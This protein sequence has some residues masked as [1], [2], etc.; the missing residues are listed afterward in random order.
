LGHEQHP[1]DIEEDGIAVDT[2][3]PSCDESGNTTFES[4]EELT[5]SDDDTAIAAK[6]PA[7]GGSAPATGGVTGGSAPATGGKKSGASIF[8]NGYFYIKGHEL[9]LRMY[10]FNKWMAP[11][12]NGIG[13]LPTSTKTITP[14]LIGESR[15]HPTRSL[16]LLKAWMLWRAR[17][18]PGWV[19]GSAS[20]Q[21]LFREEE[22]Q[23][24]LE[25]K[26]LQPQTDGLL[27]NPSASK[28]LREW[29]P[30]VVTLLSQPLAAS[31]AKGD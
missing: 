18:A 22:D 9:D 20:R 28:L 6:K 7:T 1:S 15:E 24:Y 21:R 16:L 4:S 10:I 31:S 27:G 30:Q 26:S 23:L 11:L 17:G 3:E 19:E 13:K 5:D 8:D 29:A 12:P 25:I 2:D 14:T